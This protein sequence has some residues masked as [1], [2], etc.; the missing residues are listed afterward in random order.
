[1][2]QEHESPKLSSPSV[3]ATQ[4]PEHHEGIIYVVVV[5][6]ICVVLLTINAK[7]RLINIYEQLL[8]IAFEGGL[9]LRFY[10]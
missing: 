9:G 4:P 10:L 3:F 7:E 1:M 6:L 8:M 5:P 2:T